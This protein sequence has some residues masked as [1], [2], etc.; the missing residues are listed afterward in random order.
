MVHLN[1]YKALFLSVHIPNGRIFIKSLV[2]CTLL[3]GNSIKDSLIGDYCYP[4]CEDPSSIITFN[5]D[6]SFSLKTRL[7][8]GISQWGKWEIDGKN[9]LL[10]T[11]KVESPRNLH[12]LPPPQILT[13]LK[14][15][16][17]RIES[18]QYIKK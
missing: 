6:D 2:L 10:K 14:N 7:Y 17:I 4:N 8:G 11:F 18:I 5:E 9:V 15:K 1:Y 13:I 16:D 3:H 12:Q